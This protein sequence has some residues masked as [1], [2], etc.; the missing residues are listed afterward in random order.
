MLP[1]VTYGDGTVRYN[2]KRRRWIGRYEKHTG[3]AIRQRGWVS[4]ETE[5]ECRRKL[6][7]AIRTSRDLPAFDARL[8]LDTFLERWLEDMETTVR[9]RT[10][11]NHASRIRHHIAPRLGGHRL[12]DLRAAHITAFR[13]ELAASLS[14]RSV[15]HVL[16]TLR[17]ALG[18]AVEWQMVP[19]NE[20]AFVRGLH[21]PER[22][23]QPLTTAEARR[24]MVQ[25]EGDPWE[26]M[27]VLAATLG[28]RQSEILGLRWR[29]LRD[30]R[31]EVRKT[32]T[33]HRGVATLEDPKTERS[34]RTL[35]L[36]L[37]ARAILARRRTEQAADREAAAQWNPLFDKGYDLVFTATDG[38]PIERTAVTRALARHLEAAGL[39]KV[40][41]HDLR[42]TATAWL[43]ELGLSMR[44]VADVLGH[45]RP[46]IT[47]D[48]YSH[49]GGTA[50][51]KAAAALDL[52]LDG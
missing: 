30:G 1:I 36:P 18:R 33:W 43:L 22:D 42:H 9:A 20:A 38:Y 35:T 15:N 4:G 16:S 5:A 47:A 52:A 14:P 17:Y 44:E 29:D 32:L 8:R 27:Y 3:R 25:V 40:R 26:G 48:V 13:D 39:P 28:L 41:F 21:V 46:S 6:R 34:H 7:E 19:R 37:Q 45:S 23:G 49:L 2:A 24:L 12:V 51:P 50:A 31:L 10:A 11:D